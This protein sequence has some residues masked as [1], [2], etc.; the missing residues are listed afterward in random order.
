MRA[1]WRLVLWA[2][3]GIAVVG[4][5]V[6]VPGWQRARTRQHFSSFVAGDPH[7]GSELFEREGCHD[8]HSMNGR[9][10]QVGPDLSLPAA[11]QTPDDLVA[12]MW[13]HAPAM[14]ERME[15]Q[16]VTPPQL[17]AKDVADLF[18]FLYVSRYTDPQGDAEKGRKLFADRGCVRCHN[19]SAPG[20]R[21][22]PDLSTTGADTPLAWA[23][24]MWNHAPAM[25]ARM[26]S[27]GLKWPQFSGPEMND[28]LA[29]VRSISSGPRSEYQLLAADP[30]HG[31]A[32]FR[33]KGCGTCHGLGGEHRGPGPNLGLGATTGATLVQFAGEIWNHSPAMWREMQTR[34]TQRPA[35]QGNEMA[36]LVAF[37]FSIRYFE[38]AG[39]AERGQ[40]IFAA[41]GCS[42][43][44]G[45]D[46]TGTDIA[47]ALRRPERSY[48]SITLGTAVWE[49]GPKMYKQAK[50]SGVAWPKLETADVA[51]LIAFLNRPAQR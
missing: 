9:G 39:S 18:A 14:W 33:E 42:R 16:G 48:N 13:N 1:R 24:T 50:Q 4:L 44:H 25:E 26:K 29:Y 23:Q 21:I 34:G 6:A 17:D 36:D 45:G 41:R 49:H 19:P 22:G 15:A 51:D 38:A 27:M 43:C 47:P 3:S 46:A 32:V 35:F 30:E 12:E 2:L 5:L 40:A 31:A 7:R 20:T 8:C 11:T 10:G 37:L 28:L